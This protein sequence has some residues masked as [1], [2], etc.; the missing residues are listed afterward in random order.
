MAPRTS[1]DVRYQTFLSSTFGDLRDE[2]DA[3]TR[4]ILGMERCI[5]AGMEL[6]GA[7][8]RP[9]W[10]VITSVL[11][12]TD[13]LVLI[14]GSRYGSIKPGGRRSFTHAEYRYAVERDVPVLAFLPHADRTLRED[15]R[16]PEESAQR[17]LAQFRREVEGSGVQ[18]DYWRDPQDLAHRV[19]GAL[20]K[21]F[22]ST[23]RPGWRR[24]LSTAS[25]LTE[26]A[27]ARS[28]SVL[29]GLALGSTTSSEASRHPVRDDAGV[30]IV[31]EPEVAVQ[32]AEKIAA[33][34]QGVSELV[35]AARSNSDAALATWSA[36]LGHRDLPHTPSQVGHPSALAVAGTALQEVPWHPLPR[37]AE[38]TCE[39]A[40]TD[41]GGIRIY[42]QPFGFRDGIQG[43][44][45]PA[46]DL[47]V[48]A[49]IV[50]RALQLLVL[51]SD[52]AAYDGDW[53]LL[54]R[55]QNASN[56]P[57]LNNEGLTN[58]RLARDYEER[59]RCSVHQARVAPRLVAERLLRNLFR[60]FPGAAAQ[61][62]ALIQ[63]EDE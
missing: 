31:L 37:N 63:P 39:V 55:T 44:Y 8:P 38:A 1:N 46:L 56:L 6:F 59:T 53:L 25:N 26:E 22:A 20:W 43:S 4:Q 54:V 10:A 16:E 36:R 5:P 51:M 17:K 41:K 21:A 11:D 58:E 14:L 33:S 47:A 19:S 18:V 61:Y 50:R 30:L 28:R 7:S 12:V 40:V 32:N 52:A 45:D 24:G 48:P 2:R 34:V 23:P 9:S 13:Y 27:P 3:V 15:Q 35:A 49:V 57:A 60:Q 42:S 62:S 29:T